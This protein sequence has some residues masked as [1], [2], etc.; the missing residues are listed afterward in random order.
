MPY[1]LAKHRQQGPCLLVV[2]QYCPKVSTSIGTHTMQE[3]LAPDY[4][5]EFIERDEES[6][7]ISSL[8]NVVDMI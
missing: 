8:K 3:R 6:S 7:C 2:K 1:F 4:L 5:L